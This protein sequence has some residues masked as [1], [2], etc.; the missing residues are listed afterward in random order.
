M[1]YMNN[2]WSSNKTYNKSILACELLVL[3]PAGDHV[4]WGHHVAQRA[5]FIVGPSEVRV[6]SGQ[7][8]GGHYFR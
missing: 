7:H 4:H 8:L 5:F 2:D 1:I 3:L 6:T